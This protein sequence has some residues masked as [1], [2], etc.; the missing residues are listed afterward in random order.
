M[1]STIKETRMIKRDFKKF[2]F[3]LYNYK[4]NSVILCDNVYYISNFSLQSHLNSFYDKL[5]CRGNLAHYLTTSN[6]TSV[7]VRLHLSPRLIN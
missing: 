3:R 4:R 6:G 5:L 7:N 2:Y 1:S